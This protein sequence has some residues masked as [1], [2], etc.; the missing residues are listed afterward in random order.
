MRV[1]G[2]V[3]MQAK[4]AR[5]SGRRMSEQCAVTRLNESIESSSIASGVI[6]LQRIIGHC[7]AN[8]IQRVQGGSVGT[9]T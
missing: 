7:S 1:L 9:K 4:V 2:I 3:V 5:L 6:P 8:R